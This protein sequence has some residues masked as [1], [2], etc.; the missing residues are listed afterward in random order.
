MTSFIL[1][2]LIMTQSP[3]VARRDRP[4]GITLLV[5]E[6][7]T[8]PR[9][10]FRVALRSG[11]A[12]ETEDQLGIARIHSEMVLRG[13][14][15][16]SR[17]EFAE[18]IESLGS[19]LSD[20]VGSD[21][22]VWGGEAL[23][24]QFE[25]TFSLLAEAL[26]QP[27]FAQAETDRLVRECEADRLMR[28]DDDSTLARLFFR[29]IVYARHPYGR[30]IIGSTKTLKSITSDKLRA[31]HKARVVK[32]N[33]IIAAS[34]D[35]SLAQLE[36]LIDEYLGSLPKGSKGDAA[37]SAPTD[38]QG[39]KLYLID[40]PERTQSQILM[41]RPGLKAANPDFLAANV[42]TTAFG[43]TFTAPLMHEV[44]EVRGWSYGA[45]ASLAESRERGAFALSS[46]PAE[47]DT[48]PCVQLM[49]DLYGKFVRGEYPN[50]L[51]QFARGYLLNQFP[52]AIATPDARVAEHL[53]A[54]LLNL[55]KDSVATYVDRLSHLSLNDVRLVPRRY[56]DEAG[57]FIVVV[58]TAATLEP[59]LRALPFINEVQVLPFDAELP[60]DWTWEK[61]DE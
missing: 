27:A 19:A 18:A 55:P 40:K 34:G 20:D 48:A 33:M 39:I 45:Y 43:G 3:L 23:S 53:N 29:R 9:V 28:R 57:L 8:L 59:Q 46:A 41:G 21:N 31:W 49:F 24:R 22:T 58:G 42:A 38:P 13:T 37:I 52:F 7:H 35:V 10:A 16:R 14:K 1:C 61:E 60:S 11:Q 12:V 47:G 6:D 30:D 56:L 5:A 51:F 2:A 54:E 44:R 36:R 17:A 32:S 26:T 25:T 4:D 15:A 50:E